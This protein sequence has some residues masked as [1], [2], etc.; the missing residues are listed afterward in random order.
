MENI[1]RRLLIAIIVLISLVGIT[2]ILYYP[3]SELMVSSFSRDSEASK[4][5]PKHITSISGSKSQHLRI[6]MGV[7]IANGLLYVTDSGN[8]RLSIY[9]QSGK[10]KQGIDLRANTKSNQPVDIAIDHLNRIYISML[11]EENK[12]AVYS[13]NGKFLYQFPDGASSDTAIYAKPGKPIALFATRE[14]LYI[15]DVVDQDVKVYNYAGELVLK[16]GRPGSNKGEFLY[17]NGIVADKKGNIYVSDSNNSRVQV[18]N[19]KGE[20][21]YLFTGPKREPLALPRGIAF[22]GLGR[23]HVVD[24]LRHKV[25][26][27][28]KKGAFLF[29]YASYG[30]LDENLA[31]PNDIAINSKTGHIFIADKI[32]NRV[33]IWK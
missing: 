9:T 21:L 33:S 17:P 1:N 15:T 28:T 8:G 12:V 10:F 20:F 2:G 30:K 26:V 19:E 22:D 32:N 27:F 29:T 13:D 6:P 11:G 18:F 24:T 4:A 5:H 14:K 3:L 25:F 7:G 23:I 16:F 31:N